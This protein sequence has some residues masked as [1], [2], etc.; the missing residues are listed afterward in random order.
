MQEQKSA[1]EQKQGTGASEALVPP[2]AEPS[3]PSASLDREQ[4]NKE[5][6][7]RTER[8]KEEMRAFPKIQIPGVEGPRGSA[9]F[10]STDGS[11][12]IIND[13][14]Y[15]LKVAPGGIHSFGGKE[16]TVIKKWSGSDSGG[17]VNVSP[18]EVRAQRDEARAKKAEAEPKPAPT[19]PDAKLEP[20]KE[21][22]KKVPGEK[23]Q[24]KKKRIMP[25]AIEGVPG[26]YAE[27][28]MEGI[29]WHQAASGE[30]ILKHPSGAVTFATPE[31]VASRAEAEKRQQEIA[32]QLQKTA[33]TSF[34][35]PPK[36]PETAKPQVVASPEP[37]K[38]MSE[39]E[40]R[41]KKISSP[42]EIQ[43]QREKIIQELRDRPKKIEKIERF[44]SERYVQNILLKQ[45]LKKQE[46][47]ARGVP[48]TEKAAPTAVEHV[49]EVPVRRKN[50]Q[51]RTIDPQKYEGVDILPLDDIIL[52]SEKM[53]LFYE[54]LDHID[55][56]MM[57][58]ADGM[59]II[60][61]YL[62]QKELLTDEEKTFLEYA[63]HE[64]SKWYTR[65]ETIAKNLKD[66][67]DANRSNNEY[68]RE[69]ILS[70]AINKRDEFPDWERA[71][72]NELGARG[73]TLWK[74]LK[75]F[76]GL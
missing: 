50:E 56:K 17:W 72:H 51:W 49:V 31:Q 29:T 36:P 75:S 1:A 20:Q 9:W 73:P 43:K 8:S 28:S 11:M 65:A 3:Q 68:N 18:E 58:G 27:K 39:E 59:H 26:V 64:F 66:D 55:Q 69:D 16:N 76:V 45:A 63:R 67:F 62:H 14:G 41:R 60:G 25:E 34:E 42:E 48:A 38:T 71:R 4:I 12:R 2:R 40:I 70:Y 22:V 15:V 53:K 74:W 13:D 57:R 24:P 61:K 32:E 30:W 5:R 37:Q 35:K 47:A 44:Q 33:Q 21:P 19:V 7:E 52:D 10:D 46:A 6:R 23:D 54:L